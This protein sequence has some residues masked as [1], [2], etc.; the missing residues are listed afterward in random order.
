M[1]GNSQSLGTIDGVLL[2]LGGVVY[3]GG[4]PLPGAIDAVDRLRASGI[5]VRFITN[6]TR[7]CRR[8][9]IADLARMG[10]RTAN[11]ELL[12]PALMARTYLAAHR[13][14][15]HLVVHPDLA[16][17]FSGLARSGPEAVVVGDA[18]SSFDYAHL[19]AAYRSLVAGAEFLA[20]ALNRNFLDDDGALSLDAGPFV[21]ALEYASRREAKVFGKPSPEFFAA[22]L[23]TLG[24]SRRTT[25]MIGD[26]AESDVGGA[27]AAGI[28]AILVKTGKYHAGDETRLRSPPM[29]VADTLADAVS[30]ILRQRRLTA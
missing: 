23:D 5:A 29:L 17:D 28:N 7:R 25:V 22:A 12:T 10:L 2:D 16:E 15:P 4:T 21:K 13:L 1:H 30:A 3:V 24:S 9:V 18:G 27:M 14:K 20:L 8:Q 11:A 26:D 19:N 6:T